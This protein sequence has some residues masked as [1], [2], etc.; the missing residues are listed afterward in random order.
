MVSETAVNVAS[1]GKPFYKKKRSLP[2]CAK[3][4]LNVAKNR[5]I[6]VLRLIIC[7][8]LHNALI[9]MEQSAY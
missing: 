4:L 2:F 1:A 9:V 7:V 3:Q 6:C 8:Q 5:K